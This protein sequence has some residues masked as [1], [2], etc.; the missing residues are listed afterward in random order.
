MENI[1]NTKYKQVKDNFSELNVFLVSRQYDSWNQNTEGNNEKCICSVFVNGF[2]PQM[3][4]IL[5]LFP[6]LAE[7]H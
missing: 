3:N 4:P 1:L 5:S 6:I 2:I 7:T